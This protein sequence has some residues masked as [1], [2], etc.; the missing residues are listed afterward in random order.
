MPFEFGGWILNIFLRFVGTENA[1]TY[2][3]CSEYE[4]YLIK[5][6]KLLNNLYL[7]KLKVYIKFYIKNSKCHV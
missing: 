4:L 2:L 5:T 3:P 1:K 6:I 7:V